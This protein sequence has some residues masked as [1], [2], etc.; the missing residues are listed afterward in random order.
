MMKPKYSYFSGYYMGFL[1]LQVMTST[2]EE[3]TVVTSTGHLMAT[4][5]GQAELS[6]QL[7]PPQSAEHMEVSWFKGSHFKL[8]HLY[9]DG[10][11]VNGKTAPEYMDRI[12]FVKEAIEDGKVTLRLHNISISDN[13][14]YQC[15]FKD[16]EFRGVAVMNLSVTALGLET[17]ICIQA[18]STGGLMVECNSGGWFPQPQ[19]EWRDDKGE[20]V[21]HLSKSYSQDEV[22]LFYVKMIVFLTNKSQGNVICYIRNPLSSEEKQI[23]IFLADALFHPVHIWL[24]VLISIFFVA[25]LL[26]GVLL[27]CQ[28]LKLTGSRYDFIHLLNTSYAQLL[29]FGCSCIMPII[30]VLFRRRVSLSDP[31]F[32]L[33]NDWIW[34]VSKVVVMLMFFYCGLIF[35]LYLSIKG[36]SRKKIFGKNRQIHKQQ[37]VEMET[38]HAK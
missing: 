1:F 29:C 2:P 11:E 28:C 15:S 17:Q 5:G 26:I 38:L 16:S 37:N 21:P 30:Y 22:G 9:R 19:M 8:V 33:Y 20:V 10:R 35:C 36:C 34:N 12:E 23:S 3:W 18:P 25:V 32:F 14:L 31:L 7:S 6:C 24:I 4:V 27:L 13:G